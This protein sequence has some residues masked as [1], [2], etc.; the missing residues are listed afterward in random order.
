[1]VRGHGDGRWL[2][3]VEWMDGERNSCLREALEKWRDWQ[4]VCSRGE[5]RDGVQRNGSQQS[6]K[7]VKKYGRDRLSAG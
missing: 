2:F 7:K 1:M 3:L 4:C 5:E 6:F